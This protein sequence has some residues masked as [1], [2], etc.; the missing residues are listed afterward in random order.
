MTDPEMRPHDQHCDRCDLAEFSGITYE[1][2]HR[3]GARFTGITLV[4]DREA[5][6]AGSHRGYN[7]QID[8]PMFWGYIK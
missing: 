5:G 2:A 8:E 7:E 4:C 3:C 1:A 6:H